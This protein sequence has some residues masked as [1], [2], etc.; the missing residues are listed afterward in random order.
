MVFIWLLIAHVI[1]DIAIQ[2][3]WVAQNK[4]K[5][6]I[7]LSWHTIIW[8]GCICIALEYMGMMSMWKFFFLVSGHLFC[9]LWKCKSTNK[10]PSWHLYADQMFH[11]FQCFIVGLF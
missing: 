1:G 11:L 9:D 8:A 6:I 5:F 3:D 2:S 10:F 7:V 4:G